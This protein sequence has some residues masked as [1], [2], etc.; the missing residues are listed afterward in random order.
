MRAKKDT[1]YYSVKIGFNRGEEIDFN[2]A[3]KKLETD[4]HE[5]IRISNKRSQLAMNKADVMS[6]K[7]MRLATSTRKKEKKRA[8]YAKHK[9]RK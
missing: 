1:Y 6:E 9:N 4:V 2:T 7:F 5:S 8:F 3:E